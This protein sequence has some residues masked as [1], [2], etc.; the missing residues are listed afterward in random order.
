M[1]E[2]Q[3][4]VESVETNE[5]LEKAKGFWTRFSK[6]IIYI[7]SAIILL[8]G[9]WLAYKNLV[10]AP[11]IEKAANALYPVENLFGKMVQAGYN[12][13]T[14]A[15][16]L[17]GKKGE[18]SGVLKIAKEFSGTPS[19]NLA[20]YIAGACYLHNKEFQKAIDHLKD[21]S[22]D[23]Q[24]FQS[25]AY[26]MLG[27]A[28]AELKKNDDAISYYKKAISV[29]NSKDES[30]RFASL[31]RAALFCEKIGKTQDAIEY[32]QEIKNTI[33]P[34]FFNQ[35]GIDFKVD[36]YLARLGITN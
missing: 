34:N 27:D 19:A 6:P 28:H 4:I 26:R 29:A 16:V 5:I 10:L 14:I 13:D 32:Y 9:G 30:T 24:Q 12:K 22:T 35:T 18:F 3:N 1:A 25:A 36:K 20:H 8:G 11:K 2:N 23:A 15:L 33:T 21:F 31:S 17:D 7:G